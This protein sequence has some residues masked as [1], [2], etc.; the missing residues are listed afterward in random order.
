MPYFDNNVRTD[1]YIKQILG[2]KHR[3][4]A[5]V[6]GWGLGVMGLIVLS[7]WYLDIAILKSI[8]PNWATMKANTAVGFALSGATL[9][10][11]NLQQ[12]SRPTQRLAQLLAALILLNGLI[13]LA[14]YYLGL[15]ARF[16]DELLIRDVGT[17]ADLAPGRMSAATAFAFCLTAIALLNSLSHHY[18]IAQFTAACL[19][20]V[21][22]L[23]VI[24][25]IY[26]V[27]SL[28]SVFIYQSMAI[29]T[30]LAFCI[31]S[32]AIL[33][34]HPNHGS[35]AIITGP[36]S[37]GRM[38]RR[39][40][41]VAI[42]APIIIGFVVKMLVL[43]P[44]EIE[45]TLG[46]AVL[47]SLTIGTL[48]IFIYANAL[49]LHTLDLNRQATAAELFQ[50]KEKYRAIVENAREGIF[51][52][53]PNGRIFTANSSLAEMLNYP[54]TITL[55][56][57]NLNFSRGLF[58]EISDYQ[59]CF[60]A[61]QHHSQVN[62]FEAQ[63][64]CRDQSKIW[65]II[66]A[67]TVHDP[68]GN[69]LFY[70]GSITNVTER[71][72]LREQLRQAQ[73]MEAIGRL[74]GGVAHDFN[75][76]LTVINGYSD[77]ALRLLE[78]EH[79][80]QKRIREVLKAGNR[81]AA[82][83]KQL[84]AF[85]RKQLTQTEVLDLNHIIQ[86][87]Q[88]MIPR[89]IGSNIELTTKLHPEI[90]HINADKAQMEQIIMNLIVNARD[91]MPEG[92]NILIETAN[93]TADGAYAKQLLGIEPGE[94]VRLSVTD[95]GLG[96]D[97]ETRAHI[98]E[99]FFT[100]KDIQ[101]TGLG[102]SIVYGIVKQSGGDILVYS[103]LGVGTTFKIYLPIVSEPIAPKEEVKAY[104][105]SPLGHKSV[106]VIEDSKQI[107]ELLIQTLE[108]Q[109]FTVYAAENGDAAVQFCQT[110]SEP[111]DL[112]I[113][114]LIMPGLGIKE[115]SQVIRQK[116]PAVQFLYISGYTNNSI[117]YNQLVKM[118]AHFLAKPF[119]LD[120]LYQALFKVFVPHTP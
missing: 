56:N 6:C 45:H 57:A 94:Y 112:V 5:S 71:K 69:V 11:H 48:I 101:G 44:N 54:S 117:Q 25:Y 76:I 61:L 27:N 39:L 47:V 116:H 70:E 8:H 18:R 106:L 91:A 107:R 79:P 53:L 20:F 85:S 100:T 78:P 46:I 93:I 24:G 89:L 87:L 59:E 33:I 50:A 52:A 111:L 35:M 84:L 67:R 32:A 19:G 90:A 41:P 104:I 99:P 60:E 119:S 95:T 23:G 109:E 42:V 3:F 92:G 113:S 118:E 36:T 83:T 62:E 120:D 63:L 102:L 13:V 88:G 108:E 37:G 115:F 96:M 43:T 1:K 28:Y 7:G 105:H 58:A 17:P 16:I 73:R 34:T 103:E 74:A 98:F 10:L 97:A 64:V 30:A 72:Q 12:P 14:E 2:D 55:L 51:Q 15:D 9:T 114:D 4:V 80:A 40:L 68:Q 49:S 65:T 81:A 110:H 77:I 75:N 26:N 86:E 66:N 22:V 21:A 82:L 31:S 38:A 29:H